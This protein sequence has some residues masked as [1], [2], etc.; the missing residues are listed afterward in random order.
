MVKLEA[1]S[2]MM[3]SAH[4]RGEAV[5]LKGLS[6][7]A[8]IWWWDCTRLELL[9]LALESRYGMADPFDWVSPVFSAGT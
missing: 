7:M 3:G 9:K 6:W 8:G 2:V 5:L 1:C 4:W